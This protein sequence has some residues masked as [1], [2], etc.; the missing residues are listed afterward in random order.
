MTKTQVGELSGRKHPL[1][2]A[3]DLLR[4][5]Y[6]EFAAGQPGKRFKELHERR[7]RRGNSR[8]PL[9]IAMAVVVIVIGI[10]LLVLPGPGIPFLVVGMALAGQEVFFVARALDQGELLIRKVLQRLTKASQGSRQSK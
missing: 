4:K 10:V 8:K 7:A 2:D 1:R 5:R 6:R 9:V 3:L